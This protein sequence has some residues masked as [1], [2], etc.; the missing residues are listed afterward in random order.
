MLDLQF[1]P[2]ELYSILFYLVLVPWE[3][4]LFIHITGF[5]CPWLL[6]RFSQWGALVIEERMEEEWDQDIY[7]HLPL[8]LVTTGW[9][10]PSAACQETLCIHSVHLKVC[11]H[12]V[13]CTFMLRCSNTLPFPNIWVTAFVQLPLCFPSTLTITLWIILVLNSL[14]VTQFQYGPAVFWWYKSKT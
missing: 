12:S 2:P 6:V 8:S 10:Q 13:S 14:Q 3:A 9:L 4:E 7:F 5:P 11:N 1:D